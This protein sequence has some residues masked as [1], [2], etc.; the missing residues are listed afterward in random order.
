LTGSEVTIRGIVTRLDSGSGLY[1]EEPG[2]DQSANTSNGIFIEH[3]SLFE[4]VK[5]GQQLL[6]SGRVSELGQARDTLTSLSDIS[7][8]QVCASGLELPESALSLP[9]DSRQREALEGMRVSSRGRLDVTDVYNFHRGEV[10][11]SAGGKLRAPTED[12]LPGDAAVKMARENRERSLRAS[13]AGTDGPLLHRG[14]NTPHATGVM[15]HNGRGQLLLLEHL[16]S[17][18]LPQT[19]QLDKPENTVVRVASINLLN[20]FNGDGAGGGFSAKHGA[21]TYDD[22][23][24][25]AARIRSVLAEIQP[26]MIAVQELEN[27]GFGEFSAAHSLL[28][29]LHEAVPVSWSAIETEKDRIGDAAIA[30]GLFYRA[31]VLEAL[32]TPHV[33][34]SAPFRGLSRQPLA[35]LFLERSSGTRFLAIANHLKSKGSCP[36]TGINADQRDGQS[37]WNAARLEAVRALVDW[38]KE[39]SRQYGVNHVLMLGDMNSYRKEDPI[40]H[41]GK[42]GYTDLAEH[43]SGLPQYSY[44]Y[45]GQE[46]S[47]D[48]I[49]AT[50]SLLPFV[51]QALIWHV[52]ADWPQRTELPQPWLRFS[53][54][55]PVIADLDFSQAATSD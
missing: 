10:T 4:D 9:L 42:N 20:F 53:D 21:E 32:G 45:W 14:S 34:H 31:D 52:N 23:L 33:L 18:D 44:L 17:G 38:A 46:G 39:L 7:A 30:V 28:D 2:S 1:L 12:A 16:L 15:G 54:H 11:F 5:P 26:A 6:L 43:S 47:L 51:R 48:Y 49:L 55:D 13:L 29:L 22:F 50:E 37:C 8:H 41:F 3:K 27:D 35:Q 19:P 25:Q 40:R 36:E 24:A